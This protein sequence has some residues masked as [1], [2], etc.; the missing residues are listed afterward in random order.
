MEIFLRLVG[1][2]RDRDML[3]ARSVSSPD[4]KR[5]SKLDSATYEELVK[6]RDKMLAPSFAQ[7][8]PNLPVVRAEGLYLYGLDGKRYMDFMSA[9]GVV[10]LGHN[11]PAVIDAAREQLE[12]QVHGAVGVT[13]HESVLR[14]A[15]LLPEIL[16]GHLDMFFFGNSGSEAVEGSIKLARNVTKRPGIVA[17]M[18]GF[19]GRTYGAASLTASKAIYR[20]DLDPFVSGV[21]HVPYADVYHS[22][23]PDDPEKCVEESMNSLDTVLKRLIA[24][25]Q[26]AAIIVEPIQGEGGYIVPPKEFLIRLREICTQRD[27]LLIFDEVQTGFGRTGDWF[28]AQT[29]GVQPDIMALAKGIASGFP[30]GAVCAYEELMSRWE[31]T[32]HGTTFGGNPVSCAASVAT[33]ETIRKED[34]LQKAKE[35]GK[36]LMNRLKELMTK[37]QV[38]GDARGVGLMTAIEFIVPHTDREPN[39]PAAKKFLSE[40][41]SRGVLMY[42]CGSH[43]HAVRLAPPL[44]VTHEQID[45]AMNVTDQS[46]NTIH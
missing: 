24:P 19:H 6:R 39:G 10:N 8:W 21:Y 7:D 18:G 37:H 4:K 45:E 16:P 12:K 32:V 17:F 43:G 35:N 3:L 38:I 15:A 23:H 22:S 36:Y 44:T 1:S 29:F 30:L 26:I 20:T 2:C 14:L 25:S 9:F 31:P 11:H 13:L 41:L 42:P 28:A 40:S 33:I 46:L 5:M 34:L 27:M